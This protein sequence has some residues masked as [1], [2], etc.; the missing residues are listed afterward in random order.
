MSQRFGPNGQEVERFLERLRKL[1]DADW[2]RVASAV[3]ATR[4]QLPQMMA[5]LDA[6]GD[7]NV[8]LSLMVSVGKAG[9]YYA[10]TEAATRA[11]EAARSSRGA[12]DPDLVARILARKQM[13]AQEAAAVLGQQSQRAAWDLA[14]YA[15]VDAAGALAVKGWLTPDQVATMYLPFTEVIPLASLEG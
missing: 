3:G 1:G 2:Q 9:H 8:K 6:H 5:L 15:A 13:D 7:L 10:A 4:T 11:A 12:N 14:E